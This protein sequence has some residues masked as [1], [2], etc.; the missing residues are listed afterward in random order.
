[1]SSIRGSQA[2]RVGVLADEPLRLE[3]ITSIF[4]DLPGENNK[5]L[6]PVIGTVDELLSDTSLAF[7]VVD[8]HS[9]PGGVKS[10]EAIRRRRPGLRL[11]VIGPEGDEKLILDAIMAGA[12]AYL[13]LKASPRTVRQAVD[14]VTSGSI[15]AP[16]RLLSQLIDRLLGVPDAG[17]TNEPPRLTE[18]EHQVLELILTASS[19]R[20]IARQ[21]RIEERTVQAHVGRLMRKTGAENRVDLLMR[22]SNPD[23]LRAAGITDRRLQERRRSDRHE[24]PAL[25]SR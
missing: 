15:W 23:L 25:R 19:N 18:R 7:L 3:G 20:E 10:L 8:L 21:L 22:L 6:A 2:I 24:T 11:I 17:L 5:P 9:T 4:E 16:R 14:V 13:D 1:M 12:R